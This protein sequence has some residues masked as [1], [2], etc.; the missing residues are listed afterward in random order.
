MSKNA[1][2]SAAVSN[3]VDDLQR[4]H[5]FVEQQKKRGED[6]FTLVSPEAFLRGIRDLGYRSTLTA[7]DELVDNSVQ[8]N[9]QR[10]WVF[11][12]YESGNKTKK[13]PDAI[14]VVDDGHG[15]EPEMIRI[16]VRWGGTH[17]ENDRKGFGR[18]GFGLP[19]SCVSIGKRYTIY[20]KVE[21]GE[22][23]AVPIDVEKVSATIANGG[24]VVPQAMKMIPPAFVNETVNISEFKAGTVVVIDNL[25]RLDAG[26]KTTQAFARNLLEHIGVQYRKMMPEVK[27]FVDN[28]PVEAVDPLFL[29][30]NARWYDETPVHAQSVD[31]IQFELAGKDG[32]SGFVRIR[33][34]SLPYNF[35][36][37][38]LD[39][40]IK[41][42]NHNNRF[43]IMNAN[44]GIIVC[45][46]GRQI[47][48]VTRLPWTT[49]VNFDRFWAVEIDF[50]PVLDEYFG[51]TTSKQQIVLSESLI[52][53][54]KDKGL[55]KLIEDLR[56]AMKKSRAKIKA[57]LQKRCKTPRA[58]EQAMANVQKRKPRPV[59]PSPEQAKKAEDNV[60]L[61]AKK[62]AEV[63]NEPVEE[64]KQKIEAEV[65]E[66]PY[67]VDFESM[68][69]G[70]V[71][72]PER[73]GPQYRLVVNTSHRFYSDIYEPSE[74]VPGLK[75]AIEALLFVMAETE[76]DATGDR[77]KFYKSERVYTSGRLTEVLG[78]LDDT[79]DTE[80]EASAN[81]EDEETTAPSVEA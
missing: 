41:R 22:W 9:A 51:I 21:G 75:S 42:N 76:L 73:L 2:L 48:V 25:D 40:D 64:A 34:A 63:T 3:V 58:S 60:D 24:K 38:D 67:K 70:P 15:M 33:A 77:E 14:V 1:I 37:K 46:A 68:P 62:R 29:D 43:R 74:S 81:M 78:D 49:F 39:G 4:Q 57:A 36:L 66:R 18:Y 19:S 55:E 10:V 11:P 54:L 5:E 71:F 65:K 31:P 50:D 47:D 79:G 80:D 12:S 45:R 26:F 53:I 56:R 72:R 52:D 61:Q 69:D 27:F 6:A 44:N 8:A 23:H 20:S 28:T 17:R 13:K 7:L 59:S 30:E 16:A 35:H 32:E